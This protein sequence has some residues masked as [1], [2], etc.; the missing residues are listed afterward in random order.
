MEFLLNEMDENEEEIT[1]Q[2]RMKPDLKKKYFFC[3]PKRCDISDYPF[4]ITTCVFGWMCFVIGTMAVSGVFESAYFRFGPSEELQIYKFPIETWTKWTVLVVYTFLENVIWSFMDDIVIPWK[5]NTVQDHKTIVMTISKIKTY[6][7]TTNIDILTG[8]RYWV[9]FQ[10][11]TA[12][13]DTFFVAV[14]ANAITSAWT[15]RIFLQKKKWS[16]SP[17]KIPDWANTVSQE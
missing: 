7:I 8:I 12:Q 9:T 17:H 13:F 5:M 2:E 16:N 14:I 1:V 6:F 11:Y 15:T 10:L 3:F 4:F